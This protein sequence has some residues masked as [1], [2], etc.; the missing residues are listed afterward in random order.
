MSALSFILAILTGVII[1]LL[2]QFAVNIFSEPIRELNKC[3]K[4][5]CK[6]LSFN[7]NKYLNPSKD[8][9][10][11][12][13][14]KII[15]DKIR[16]VATELLSIRNILKYNKLFSM[17]NF[18]IKDK[19]IL[20]AQKSLFGLSNNIGQNLSKGEKDLLRSYENDIKEALD[21]SFQ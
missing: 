14:L 11:K 2:G 9:M 15:S 10:T 5:I 4:E 7:R 18:S 3:K 17:L 1:V 19:N 16:E 13:E 8:I 21:I 20:E 6:V 12:E